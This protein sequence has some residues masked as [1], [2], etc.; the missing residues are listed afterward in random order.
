[1]NE[2]LFL[3]G[4]CLSVAFFALKAGMGAAAGQFGPRALFALAGLYLG[5]FAAVGAAAR[6]MAAHQNQAWLYPLLQSG[7]ALHVAMAAGMGIWGWSLL[8]PRSAEGGAR[9]LAAW[10][11]VTPCP[12]CVSSLLVSV[13]FAAMVSALSPVSVAC[14][15]A[16]VFFGL[17]GLVYVL[18]SRL[19]LGADSLGMLCLLVS[20]YFLVSLAVSPAYAKA[21]EMYALSEQFSH[22]SGI[23]VRDI[24]W[25]VVPTL[26][27]FAMGLRKGADK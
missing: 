16:A 7:I 13:M 12:V 23:R 26:G 3:I 11:V 22:G 8:R 9:K 10:L 24:A 4:V 15:L 17:S 2:T 25:L 21:S 19:R 14:I 1:M 5:L 18:G 27:I 20:A 6:W